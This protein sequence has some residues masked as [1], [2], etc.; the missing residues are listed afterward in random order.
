MEPPPDGTPWTIPV[1][2]SLAK[3]K[4]LRGAKRGRQ[5]CL[6]WLEEE[7]GQLQRLLG[8]PHSGCEGSAR[9]GEVGEIGE[10]IK[11]RGRYS[12]YSGGEQE[13][14]KQE[15]PALHIDYVPVG[16]G[17]LLPQLCLAR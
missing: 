6:D 13:E 15:T 8:A 11:P 3:Q 16:I 10:R 4:I 1:I 17:I 12:A 14:E 5:K 7:P 9:H 2:L